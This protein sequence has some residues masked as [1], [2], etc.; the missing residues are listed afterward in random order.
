M[1]YG[2]MQHRKGY[3]SD[4][5][6]IARHPK[7]HKQLI[8]NY[9]ASADFYCRELQKAHRDRI[10]YWVVIIDDKETEPC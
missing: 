1:R 6:H 7:T 10:K 5:D 9:K 8:F 2:I 4:E 3:D